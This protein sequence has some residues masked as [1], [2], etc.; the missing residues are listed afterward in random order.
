MLDPKYF[1]ASLHVG[2]ER[3]QH[4][5]GTELPVKNPACSIF[6]YFVYVLMFLYEN[7]L[8]TNSPVI[9]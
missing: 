9:T 2:H 7:G 4:A 6:E 1:Y 8:Y 3:R 5:A